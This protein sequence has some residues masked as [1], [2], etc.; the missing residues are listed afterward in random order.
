MA[1]TAPV[2][3]RHH[4]VPKFYLRGFACEPAQTPQIYGFDTQAGNRFR[5]ATTNVALERDF[6][7]VAGEQPDYVEGVLA[8]HETKFDKALRA[9]LE[10]E[11]IIDPHFEEVLGL[12]ALLA[13]RHPRGRKTMDNLISQIADHIF[14][15]IGSSEERY[16]AQIAAAFPEGQKTS[17]GVPISFEQ[18]KTADPKD[19]ITSFTTDAHIQREFEMVEHLLPLIGSRE[20]SMISAEPGAGT[21]ITSDQPV[22]LEWND[23][24][25]KRMPPGHGVNETSVFFPLSPTLLI[26]GVFGEL[27]VPNVADRRLI[28][29]FNSMQIRNHRQQLYSS[30]PEF[31]WL[32]Q[33][34]VTSSDK[35]L[36]LCRAHANL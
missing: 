3:R 31:P 35:L 15:I 9:T 12:L 22:V 25:N 14:E 19:Y 28:S 7:T 18:F 1:D 24:E 21:F 10:A 27:D 34:E 16:N 4:Y 32:Y 33:D 36:E 2:A 30:T 20:W 13:V 17:S 8:E 23:P 6:N 29:L 5:T 11:A 26:T